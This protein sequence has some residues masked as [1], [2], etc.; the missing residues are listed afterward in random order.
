MPNGAGNWGWLEPLRWPIRAV[1]ILLGHVLLALVLIT[2]IWFLEGYTHW[3]YGGELPLLWG[4]V[5]LEWAF[6]TMD[7]GV[8]A[9]FIARGLFEAARELFQ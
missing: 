8:L 3:L 7:A 9:L 6:D 5:P 4:R 1:V 2:G